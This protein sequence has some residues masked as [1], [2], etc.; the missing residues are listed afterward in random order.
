MKV[1]AILDLEGRGSNWISDEDRSGG[2]ER[3]MIRDS[4]IFSR[5]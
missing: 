3:V 5:R 4:L 1:W 2:K